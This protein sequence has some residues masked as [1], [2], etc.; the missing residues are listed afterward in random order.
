M[1]HRHVLSE[2]EITMSHITGKSTILIDHQKI[3]TGT[4][5]PETYISFFAD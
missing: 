4:S 3:N 1:K 2:N 5:T